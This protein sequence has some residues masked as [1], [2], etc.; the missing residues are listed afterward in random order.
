VGLVA[1]AP[2]SL[3]NI[4]I[5]EFATLNINSNKIKLLLVF[6]EYNRRNLQKYKTISE[7]FDTKE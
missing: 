7:I 6:S 2:V 3:K 5:G 1:E 4:N